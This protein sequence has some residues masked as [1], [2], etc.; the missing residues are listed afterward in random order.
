MRVPGGFGFSGQQSAHRDDNEV[1]GL[2]SGPFPYGKGHTPRE[3]GPARR[4]QSRQ[5]ESSIAATK[6][7]SIYNEK[8]KVR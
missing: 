5:L 6:Y 4:I 7:S 2:S 3:R 8:G 1:V